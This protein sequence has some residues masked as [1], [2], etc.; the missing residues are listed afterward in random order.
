MRKSAIRPAFSLARNMTFAILEWI[1]AICSHVPDKGEE[2]VRYYCY[3]INGV[4]GKR[5]MG[6]HDESL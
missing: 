6:D 1:A 3:Y 5:K 2:I 4:R